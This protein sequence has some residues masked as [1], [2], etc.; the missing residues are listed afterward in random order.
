M[1]ERELEASRQHLARLEEQ[2]QQS[3]FVLWNKEQ[4]DGRLGEILD[5]IDSDELD[6]AVDTSIIAAQKMA[7]VVEENNWLLALG[8]SGLTNETIIKVW[9]L[10]LKLDQDMVDET[11]QP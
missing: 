8:G 5:Q 2:N 11:E 7:K 9:D 1:S 4:A 3:L 6:E 10:K